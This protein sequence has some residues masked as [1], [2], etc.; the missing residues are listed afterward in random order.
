MTCESRHEGGTHRA[1][2][3]EIAYE[4]R[5][6]KG[7][8]EGVRLVARPKKRREHLIASQSED[9]AGQGYRAG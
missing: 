2:C 7:N 3:E 6:A 1:L 8:D 9:P 5:N 4:I